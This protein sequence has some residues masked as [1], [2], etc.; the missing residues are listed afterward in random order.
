MMQLIKGIDSV[1]VLAR[2]SKHMGHW[3]ASAPG[4]GVATIPVMPYLAV[5]KL[6]VMREWVLECRS[7]NLFVLIFSRGLMA[8]RTKCVA[9]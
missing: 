8:S 9:I 3:G 5:L 4:G 6:K 7:L 1:A 2:M